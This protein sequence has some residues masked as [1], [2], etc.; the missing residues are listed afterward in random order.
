MP[1]RELVPGLLLVATCVAG[2]YIMNR[3]V[4]TVS[5]LIWAVFIGMAVAAVRAPGVTLLPGSRFASRTLLRVGVA[6]LGFRLALPQLIAVGVPGLGVVAT[7]VPL[8]MMG[9]VW[10]AR[11]LGCSPGLGL[12]IGSGSAICGAS[13]VVAVDAVAES[14][15]SEVSVAVATVTVFG[16][17]AML[18]LP[19]LQ[20]SVLHLSV[21]QYG[22]WAGASIHEVAQVVA[23]AAPQGPAAVRVAT[24]IKLTRV[25]MLLPVVLFLG[26]RHRRGNPGATRRGLPVP[27]FVLGFLACVL[28]ASTAV[29]PGSVVTS[30]TTV[31]TLLLAA[32]LAGL[33]L[34]VD[35]R[36]VARLG[37]RPVV[38]GAGA[39]GLAAFSSLGM[40]ALLVRP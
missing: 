9:T 7:V 37:W 25:L 22:T 40:T 13:A 34:G 28:V 20:L 2:A 17:A 8:T 21:R 35:F 32:A 3:F 23:A 1:G 26:L 31:D 12:L 5:P 4:P 18:L 29:L 10:L 27:L 16:T 14:E 11:R 24:V 33:G 39:W 36:Q 30:A 6:L 19:F 38:L 15:E